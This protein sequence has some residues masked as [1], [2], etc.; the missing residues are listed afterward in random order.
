MIKRSVEKL[1]RGGK[2]DL[3]A[4]SQLDDEDIPEWNSFVREIGAPGIS[5]RIIFHKVNAFL[6]KLDLVPIEKARKLAKIIQTEGVDPLIPA[7]KEHVTSKRSHN[8]N[9]D[10]V[11]ES[12]DSSESNRA[13]ACYLQAKKTTY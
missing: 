13:G 2:I 1:K 7:L 10:D 5:N 9:Q 11:E 4:L 12:D 3:P 6:K 8:D